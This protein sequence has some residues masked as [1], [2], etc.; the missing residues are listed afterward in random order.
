MNALGRRNAGILA[1]ILCLILLVVAL[2]VR[3]H[4]HPANG[5]VGRPGQVAPSGALT[6]SEAGSAAPQ[7]TYPEIKARHPWRIA[8]IPKFKFLGETGSLSLYWLSAWEGAQKAGADFGVTVSLIT[9]QVRG[10]TDADY[11]E[12]QIRLIADLIAHDQVDGLV[13]AAFDS[14]RLGPIV[15]KAIGAGIPTIAVDTP[16][17]CDRVLT[18]VAYDNFHAGQAMGQWVVAQ[19]GGKG[20]ALIIDGPQ[21][22]Q[23]AV[24]RRHG[25]LTGLGSGNIDILKAKSGDWE[26][27]PAR[28]LV[29]DWLEQEGEVDVIL[30]ANDNM[31]IG[32]AQ[33][34]ED[35]QRSGILIT[36]FDAT[37]LALEAIRQ[38][39]I[40][41][42]IDQEP[43]VQVRLA[44]QL[45]IRHLE[46]KETFPPVVYLPG[47]KLV[48]RSTLGA[49]LPQ[50]TR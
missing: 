34:V 25:F 50:A 17:N 41:A 22:Q 12:P 27:A 40:S 48:T 3:A 35:E 44:I 49:A 11:V 24:A 42:T 7:P 19:L 39:R 29:K 31:A 8:F 33:A 10:S 1:S 9:S 6:L 14:N 18:F 2:M 46:T 47:I 28:R 15:D 16:I 30:A 38:G 5:A 37:S 21:D 45:L 23:N 13:V 36:G 32:A 43:G 26:T 20:K 4:A